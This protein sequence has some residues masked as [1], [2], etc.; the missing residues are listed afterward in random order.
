M[1]VTFGRDKPRFGFV[2]YV[3][4]LVGTTRRKVN[5][6]SKLESLA[7]Q[8]STTMDTIRPITKDSKEALHT[9]IIGWVAYFRAMPRDNL[10]ILEAKKF[11]ISYEY[12]DDEFLNSPMVYVI[13][14]AFSCQESGRPVDYVDRYMYSIPSKNTM[15]VVMDRK[16]QSYKDPMLMLPDSSPDMYETPA[17][18][19][20]P[21]MYGG[22]SNSMVVVSEVLDQL[23]NMCD[24]AIEMHFSPSVLQRDEAYAL[25]RQRDSTEI[26]DTLFRKK[27]LMDRFV[28]DLF[29]LFYPCSVACARRHGYNL[30]AAKPIMHAKSFVSGILYHVRAAVCVMGANGLL[31]FT[32]A[33]LVL[34]HTGYTRAGEVTDFF[35]VQ[36]P[37]DYL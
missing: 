7:C 35:L 23:Q 13:R 25:S 11:E 6:D 27:L 9:C 33:T 29:S 2:K 14:V 12:T 31:F 22:S 4:S 10:N 1:Y 32:Y 37:L 24:M 34:W 19:M 15:I 3:N 17:S 28:T 36:N 21:H 16:L 30:I 18:L 8:V 20:Y 5:K 26:C